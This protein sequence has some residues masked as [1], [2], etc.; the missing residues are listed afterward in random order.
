ME[1]NKEQ[2]KILKQKISSFKDN[3][4]KLID[5]SN[6]VVITAHLDPDYDALASIAAMSLICKRNKKASYVVI[7]DKYD[8]LRENERKMVDWLKDKYIVLNKEEYYNT[9][10]DNDL[11]V[12]VDVNKKKMTC[13]EDE[14]E[15]F[16]NI[17]IIDHHYEDLNTIS[18]PNKLITSN[19]S[20]CSEIFFLFVEPA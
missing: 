16:K 4:I 8:E 15:R 12:T 13:F 19:V 2:P 17:A 1:T 6:Q 18:T 5:D 7:D 9:A 20:S 3:L 10:T 14:Y 11:L